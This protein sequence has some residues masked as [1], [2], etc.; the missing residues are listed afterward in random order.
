MT[1]RGNRNLITQIQ[2]AS[3][4]EYATVSV[5]DSDYV[6][7]SIDDMCL[8]NVSSCLHLIK[9]RKIKYRVFE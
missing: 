7:S 8:Q 3:G 9:Y 6:G 1:G 2:F 4:W 5:I